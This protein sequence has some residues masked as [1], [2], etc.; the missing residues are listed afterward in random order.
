MDFDVRLFIMHSNHSYCCF[1]ALVAQ[2]DSA[3]ALDPCIVRS[4]KMCVPCFAC[5]GHARIMFQTL[6][7]WMLARCTSSARVPHASAWCV[8]S[9]MHCVCHVFMSRLR[10]SERV[11]AYH[12]ALWFDLGTQRSLAGW[13]CCDSLALLCLGPACVI[14]CFD[15]LVLSLLSPACCPHRSHR[16]QYQTIP[17]LHG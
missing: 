12:R 13:K 4:S 9:P 7:A 16:S 1:R 10:S 17:C 14:R 3:N 8:L 11:C 2:T 15:V 6:L 5:R